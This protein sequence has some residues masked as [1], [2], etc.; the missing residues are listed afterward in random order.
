MSELQLGLLIVGAL[1]VAG[2]IFYNRTQERRVRR[3]AEQAFTSRHPD[4]LLTADPPARR[5]PSL[6]PPPKPREEAASTP[7]EE[8]L[9]DGRLDYV[10]ELSAEQPVAA[11]VMLEGW[12]GL[13]RRFGRRALLAW[14]NEDGSWRRALPG[15]SGSQTR[16]R[17]ALQLVSR[18]GVVGEAELI[19]FRSEIETLAARAGA[20]VSAP[21]M[22]EALDAARALDRSCADADIQVAFHVV[23][24]DAAGFANDAVIH[25][26]N[27]NG[28]AEQDRQRWTRSDALGRELFAVLMESDQ[29]DVVT[30]LTVTMDVPRTPDLRRS[31]ESMVLLARDLASTLGGALQDDN[32]RPLDE[33]ALS[34]IGAQLEPVGRDLERQGFAPGGALA[35]RLFS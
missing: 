7:G 8:D 34:A 13:E 33:H 22:R 23:G 32:A 30:R 24:A 6:G 3:T 16:W 2:V 28:L 29:T 9:P 21:E 14:R 10:V 15:A 5:E 1:A 25:A 12:R 35:L 20:G 17:A 11:A 27:T 26:L 19:E 18:N 31:Y 4:V